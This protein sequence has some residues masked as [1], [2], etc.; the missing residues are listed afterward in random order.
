M[1][2]LGVAWGSLSAAVARADEAPY[3]RAYLDRLLERVDRI[4]SDMEALTSA[5]EVSAKA[6]D[7]GAGF[8]V[9]GDVGMAQELSQRAGA[10]MG[11]DGRRGEAGDVVLYVLGLPSRAVEAREMLAAQFRDAAELKAGGSVVIG[12]T[13]RARLRSYGLLDEAQ[14]ACTVLIDNHASAA[15]GRL[16]DAAGRTVAPME[17]VLNAVSAWAYECE[18]FAA[19][20][21]RGRV[22]VVRQS[23]EIDT[24]RSR[25]S[26]YG[27]QRFHHDRWLDPIG[28]GDLGRAYLDGLKR[29][30]RDIGTAS[31]R[32]LSRSA[33]KVE[34][35]IR[36]DAVVW[37]RPGGRYLPHHVGTDYA[38]DPGLFRL[39]THDGS[40]PSLASPGQ[41]DYLLAVGRYETAGSW[42][43]GEPELLRRAGQGVTWIVNGYN[44][45]RADLKRNERLIDLWG[46][47]GD[48][49]V[50]V[51]DYDTRLGPV[52]SVTAEAVLWMIAVEVQGR[53]SSGDD[54]AA[55]VR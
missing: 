22:P 31:W 2:V 28:P 44:T 9:R 11:Y 8:G 10:M 26:R 34:Q 12:L 50:K 30:L 19:L 6:L 45:Q 23:F 32:N 16:T 46:P 18:L 14:Q 51:A 3:A 36:S 20:T 39:L 27:S 29:V 41:A 35:V 21:R 7:E 48:C 54:E 55:L 33:S 40:D 49:V 5:A 13:S 24:R 15:D 42:E 17:T 43:W 38:G 37:L 1:C 25:W 4:G 53:L 47:V 52:S